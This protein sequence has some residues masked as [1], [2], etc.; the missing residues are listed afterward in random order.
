MRMAV[1][2]TVEQIPRDEELER[3]ARSISDCL[4]FHTAHWTVIG[5]AS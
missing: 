2:E 1:A 3:R 4:L 5:E